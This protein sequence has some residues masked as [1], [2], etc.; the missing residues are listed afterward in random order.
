MLIVHFLQLRGNQ[1]FVLEKHIAD[2]LYE[3][4][5]M[6]ADE[7]IRFNGVHDTDGLTNFLS[8]T[9]RAFSI[10]LH[11]KSGEDMTTSKNHTIVF[12]DNVYLEF[13]PKQIHAHH[14][15]NTRRPFF[16]PPVPDLS[17]DIGLEKAPSWLELFYDLFYIATLTNFT[18]EHHIK[19]WDTLWVY[20]QWFI[21]TWW[22]WCASSLY[23][24]RYDTDDVIHHLYKLVEMCAVICMAGSSQHFLNSTSY[25]YGYIAL[26]VVLVIEYSV[27]FVV[28]VLT[29]SKSRTSFAFYVG[30]NLVSIA[31]WG[32]SLIIVERETHRILWYMGVFFEIFVNVILR[33]DKALS[34][35]ASHLAERIGL[36]SLIVLGEN[37]MGLVKVVLS[38]GN[39]VPLVGANFMAV[40]I[41]FGF[42]FMYFEDFTKEIFLHNKFHQ[43]W[44]YL[45]F[46]LHLCQIAFGIA[47]MDLVKLHQTLLQTNKDI[48][49]GETVSEVPTYA[50]EEDYPSSTVDESDDLSAEEHAKRAIKEVYPLL[51]KINIAD[52]V[53]YTKYLE[54]KDSRAMPYY[55]SG[56]PPLMES[57]SSHSVL[58]KRAPVA[59]EES[60]TFSITELVF[61]YKIFLIFGGALLVLNSLIKLLNTKLSDRNGMIIIVCRVINAGVIWGLCALPFVDIEPIILLGVMLGS[62]ILQGAIDLLD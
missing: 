39:S 47:L 54:K 18:H 45:H 35:A 4:L 36:L 13:K 31:L 23:T 9:K 17:A 30:A 1:K 62:V 42:F 10:K 48:E 61:I 22:A 21:I 7:R 51:N 15:L 2:D 60:T 16:R 14:V 6:T 29:R 8:K 50:G 34:W 43:I 37:L 52:N 19:D 25:I 53:H 33:R 26:K 20:T 38:A 5:N 27:V 24:A 44:V 11:Q 40:G 12:N 58:A 56:V 41:V 55:V 46:P 3:R 57:I 32:S 59:A 49:P 28:A